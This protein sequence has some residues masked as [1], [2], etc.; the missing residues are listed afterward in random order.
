MTQRNDATARLWI[1]NPDSLGKEVDPDLLEAAQRVW[2]RARF[3]VIR[4]LADDLDAADIL[5][6][7]VDSISRSPNGHEPIRHLD[8]YLL[9]SVAREAIRRRRRRLP[10][11]LCDSVTLDRLSAAVSVDWDRTLDDE[12]WMALLKASLDSNGRL[13]L[14]YRVLEYDWRFIAKSMGYANEHSA[15]V[16][17]RKKIDRAL[18]RIQAHHGPGLTRRFKRESHE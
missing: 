10:I 16:Q 18:E 7:I 5:E 3:V 13:M 9:R 2:D 14:E 1:R 17:F 12:R 11:T 15:E 6:A 4:Y 8:A